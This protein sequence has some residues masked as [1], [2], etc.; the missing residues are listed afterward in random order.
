MEARKWATANRECYFH[1][2]TLLYLYHASLIIHQQSTWKE[3]SSG[4]P[5]FHVFCPPQIENRGHIKY[6]MRNTCTAPR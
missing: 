1:H 3:N 2:I 6:K 5:D 4:V